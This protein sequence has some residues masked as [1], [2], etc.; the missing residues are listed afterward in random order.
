VA[1]VHASVAAE[2]DVRSTRNGP[3][4][5]D[6][7]LI[8]DRPAGHTSESCELV[9]LAKAAISAKGF[10][11]GFATS[12]TDA[13]IPMSL[14]IPA[15]KI[16]SGGYGA[17]EHSLDEWIDVEPATSLRGMEAGLATLLAVAGVA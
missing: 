13:N 5:A 10:E 7:E 12:S 4:T 2:N 16:G 6:L 17:R 8:G 9:Q 3:V 14:G 11:V 1:I 15:I